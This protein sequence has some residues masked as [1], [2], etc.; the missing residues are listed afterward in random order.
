MNKITFVGTRKIIA[1]KLTPFLLYG[2]L[3]NSMI[4]L[5]KFQ[6]KDEIAELN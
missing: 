1:L 3:V 4:V 6:L 5:L 2:T